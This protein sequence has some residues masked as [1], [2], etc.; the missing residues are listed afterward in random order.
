[1]ENVKQERNLHCLLLAFPL[2]GHVN[3]MLQFSKRLKHKGIARITLAVTKFFLKTANHF[4]SV[5]FPVETISDGFDDGGAGEVK[6]VEYYEICWKIGSETLAQLIERLRSSGSGVDCLIYDPFYPWALDVAKKLGLK[7]AMFFTQSNSVNLIYFHAY[8]RELVLPVTEAEIRIRGGLSALTREDLPSFIREYES[9]P[10]IAEMMI[11]QFRNV[12]M[13]DWIFV[14]TFYELEKEVCEWMAKIFPLKTIGPTIPSSYVDRRVPDDNEYGLSI[15]TPITD[16]CTNWLNKHRTKSVIYV[17]FGSFAQPGAEQMEE[18]AI[19]LKI[20]K[21][22]FLWVVRASE[23]A[24][25]PENYTDEVSEQGLIVTWCRQ[26]DVLAHETIGCFVT[27]CGWN[28][29][30]EAISSGVPI[31]AMPQ[32][33]DQ[34][35]NAKLVADVWKIGIRVR[36]AEEGIVRRGEIIRCIKHVMECGIG[37]EMRRSTE[38]WKKLTREAVDEGGSSDINIEE[39]VSSLM[40]L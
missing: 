39:F 10:E 1:M 38:N 9:D 2:Q 29:T 24:K 18:L 23:E 34:S 5:S 7:A 33:S 19:A 17:S 12:E 36:K 27:H 21:M 25:L 31:V 13:V 8:K 22:P 16:P 28:S 30:L 14:N 15:F 3:P 4:P 37:E 26:L 32:W 40:R 6:P 35:T 11:R 20:T